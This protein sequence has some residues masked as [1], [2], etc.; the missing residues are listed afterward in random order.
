M[1]LTSAIK[2]ASEN[3]LLGS[4]SFNSGMIEISEGKV[5][6]YDF[7]FCPDFWRCLGKGMNWTTE[8]KDKKIASMFEDPWLYYWHSLIDHLASGGTIKSFFSE[9]K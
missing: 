8:W 2:L 4:D 5:V 1:T 3:G 6:R 7:L 9:L